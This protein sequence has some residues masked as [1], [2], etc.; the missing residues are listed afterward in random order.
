MKDK[1]FHCHLQMQLDL[2]VEYLRVAHTQTNKT[3]NIEKSYNSSIL[4][5][6]S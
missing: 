3:N 2:L 5:I 4:E 1:E 6:G